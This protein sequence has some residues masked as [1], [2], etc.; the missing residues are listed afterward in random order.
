MPKNIL[1][2]AGYKVVERY[3]SRMTIFLIVI[4]PA[5][6][7]AVEKSTLLHLRKKRRGTNT[8]DLNIRASEDLSGLV[9]F[10]FVSILYFL[11]FVQ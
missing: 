7:E 4:L 8:K 3:L 10:L 11:M 1:S 6:Y 9:L 5:R 2:A